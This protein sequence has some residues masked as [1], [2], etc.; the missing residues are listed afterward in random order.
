MLKIFAPNE[1]Q[2]LFINNAN[3]KGLSTEP[4]DTPLFLSKN[5]D[6]VELWFKSDWGLAEI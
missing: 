5:E 2:M 6:L 4:Y 1:R 3:S